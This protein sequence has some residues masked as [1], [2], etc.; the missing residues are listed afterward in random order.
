MIMQIVE[1]QLLGYN[2]FLEKC[3]FSRIMCNLI[4]NIE[5]SQSALAIVGKI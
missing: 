1:C 5:S 4:K 3:I 2:T